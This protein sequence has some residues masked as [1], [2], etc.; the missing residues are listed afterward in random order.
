MRRGEG[1]LIQPPFN[2]TDT[3]IT[4]AIGDGVEQSV[5]TINRTPRAAHAFITHSGLNGG[6][7]GWVEQ[8]DRATA[9]GIAIGL[10]SHELKWKGNGHLAVGVDIP[11][12]CAET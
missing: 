5:G 10:G 8:G 12:A 2:A 4:L 9:I 6:A 11:A 3:T 1:E 7:R